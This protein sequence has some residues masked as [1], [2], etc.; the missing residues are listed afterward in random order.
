[1]KKLAILGAMPFLVAAAPTMDAETLK[2]VRCFTALMVMAG[3]VGEEETKDVAVISQYYLGRID[4]RM[5][6][7]DLEAAIAAEADGLTAPQVETLVVSC[8]DV[9][10]KRG[11]ELIVIGKA[12][13]ERGARASASTS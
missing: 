4:A 8:A 3:T 5:P 13:E 11:E 10:G 2:D 12:L 9:V 7:L 1:M 6:G